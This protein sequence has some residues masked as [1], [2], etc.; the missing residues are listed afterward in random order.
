VKKS[1]KSYRIA[2]THVML[3]NAFLA[4]FVQECLL[5]QPDSHAKKFAGQLIHTDP[6]APN[7]PANRNE[8]RLD[9]Q[10]STGEWR[11]FKNWNEG[12]SV[13]AESDSIV[14]VGT[15]VGLVRW[16]TANQSYQTFDETNG[17]SFSSVHSLCLDRQR[18]LWIS[19]TRGVVKYTNGIFTT[20]TSGNANLPNAPFTWLAVD[21]LN[22][23]YAAYDWYIANHAYVDGG[24]AMFNGTDWT[25]HDIANSFGTWGPSAI[26]VYNDTVWISEWDNF[27]IMVGSVVTPAPRWPGG[28]V[29]S[30]AVDYQDSLW[31]QSNSQKLLKYS[32]GIW[33][34]RIDGTS[35]QEIWNDPRGG[36][37]LSTRDGWY[38]PD[39][40][41]YRLDIEMLRLGQ[42]CFSWLP[43][44]VCPVPQLTRQFNSHYALSSSAQFFA[45]RWGLL[46]F[47][48]ST[49]Q[50][51]VTPKSLLSNVVYS[52]GTS[53]SGKV[54]LSAEMSIQRTDGVEWDSLGNQGWIDPEIKF[55]PDGSFWHTGVGRYATG[56][57]YDGFDALWD[58]YG[59]IRTQ[60][61][62]GFREWTPQD[63]GMQR[64]PGYY[65]PQFM[66][67]A[68]DK[69]ENVW[70][71]G[72]YNGTVMY[73]R[74][75]W[76][77]YYSNDTILP[78]GDYDRVFADSRNRIWFGTNQS[79]PNYGFTIFE[80]GRWSTFYSPQRYSISYVYQIAEDHF[81]NIWLA[82][83]GGLLKYDG[84]TFAI[85]DNT[86]SRLNS[87]TI[88]AVTVDLRGNIWAGTN[89]GLYVFNPSGPIELGPY[90]FT[91]PVD[92]LSVSAIGKIA[93]AS[94][95]T[96]PLSTLPV[97]YQLQR[98]RGVHKFW[99]VK[100]VEFSNPV[101]ALVEL[102]DSSALIGRYRYRIQ[103]V[104]SSGGIRYSSSVQFTGGT[105]S[106]S[107]LSFH[108]F[109]VGKLFFFR[110]ETRDESFTSRFEIWR[111]DSLG[112][113]FSFLT[114]VCPDSSSNNV[115]QYEVRIDSLRHSSPNIR[116]SLRVVYADSTRAE[117]K[118]VDVA[119][120]FPTMFRVSSNYPN[121]FNSST[122]FDVEMPV[123]G[124]V[125]LRLYDI[126]GREVRT[127]G[128]Q[129]DEGF[130]RLR[131][132][133]SFLATGVY[134]YSVESLGQRVTGKLVLLK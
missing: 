95:R 44:G 88:Y 66:D 33:T 80:G 73:D 134:L 68:V 3:A 125:V 18:Q 87:N 98:G 104:S 70:A 93:K 63:L 4:F 129:V 114:S 16:N 115:K 58:A 102:T 79:S 26:C 112:G 6:N 132:N 121:P 108:H 86:N 113:Q 120:L 116:Y 15:S 64:P 118:T 84:N 42:R 8:I 48:G 51:I 5:A 17:L 12:N 55:Y 22:N 41:L 20:F 90:L 110:W 29:T 105:P 37:W 126:L 9:P 94:F 82:T 50:P 25:Y 103:E 46:K 45:T 7:A 133:M 131:V 83:G 32:G 91:S 21:S 100:S 59:T 1:N 62:S 39:Q 31:A 61:P 2:F 72:W 52:L 38:V 14:W 56:L 77:P 101:P 71:T 35:W 30:L 89:T 60:G 27:Y 106:A 81:G 128:E 65:S 111:R 10:S 19:T 13:I 99:T 107:L 49:W 117:L 85:Y 28:G 119:P 53:P 47:A 54:Y 97:V 130:H 122:T 67:I 23:I 96:R 57:D 36:L 34:V 124:L 123:S 24:V 92:S 11:L 127:V 74:T 76:H 40:T 75:N 109:A 78:N 69:S 43:P